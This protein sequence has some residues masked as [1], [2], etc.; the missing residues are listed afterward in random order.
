MKSSKYWEDRIASEMWKVYNSSEDK[1]KE[2]LQFY[3]NA[4]ERVKGELYRIAEKY[5]KNG[6]L[7]LSEMH[8]QNHLESL[9]RKFGLII[10]EL[11]HDTENFAKRNMTEGFQE[12]YGLTAIAMGD[13]DFSIPNK[14]LMEKLLNTPWRGDSFSGRLWKNQKKLAVGLNELLLTGL[15]QGK[16]ITEIAVNMHNLMGTGFNECHRLVRTETMHYLNDAT[17]QRYK[18]AGVEYVQ[19]WAA[20]DERTCETC[21]H[22][23]E[24]IYLIDK[25]PVLP[26]H[27]NC[28]CTVIPVT[29]EKALEKYFREQGI[30][31]EEWKRKDSIAKDTKSGTIERVKDRGNSDV[32]T[33]GKIDRN[34]YK[35]IT[36][37][38]VTDEVIITDN[39]IQHIKDRHPND[40]ERFSKY[41]SEI[42][43][44]PD[45]IIK[46]NKPDT[47]VIL[48]E[49]VD[50]GERF[51]T[52]L[53][54]CTSKEPEGFKNSII[55]FLK[56]DEK[57]WNRYLRTK[58]ILY[59]KE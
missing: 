51:Q 20:E 10:E 55:T 4:S 29:D 50:N 38:I 1:N 59:K 15:Q 12:V 30:N 24:K 35:C 19:I 16:T 42:V 47:A 17:L 40:Y 22:Q 18:D 53:R 31:P 14:K 26:F 54:L 28:R 39:Q 46:A 27:P 13:I 7:S 34:I 48:K 9:N 37:D 56:I 23:H 33:V 41:F 21:G 44:A 3:I 58:E 6:I 36:K 11:G 45:Y 52:V 43:K 32:H 5:S 2:L 25:C 8:K 49:I 57:R